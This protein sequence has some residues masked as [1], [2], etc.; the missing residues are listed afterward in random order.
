MKGFALLAGLLGAGGA[1]VVDP[2][3]GEPTAEAPAPDAAVL[4]FERLAN[5]H[6]A[7]VGCR[8]LR[9]DAPTARVAQSHASDMARRDFFSHT[10]PDGQSP[11]D[12]LRAA[13]VTHLSAAE[14][15]AFGYP[16]ATAVLQS[17]LN[18]DGHRRNLE[19]CRYTHHGVGLRDSRWVHVFIGR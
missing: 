3:S 15:I 8:P 2:G 13:G 14:N 7:S 17:W 4:E 6:R 18:S 19:N 5:T 11:F 12:R 9:W 1:G 16:T 10:N